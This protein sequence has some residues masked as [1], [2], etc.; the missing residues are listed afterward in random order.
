M[1]NLLTALCLLPT[2]V[3]AQELHTFKNGEVAD[4]EKINQNFDLLR[5][6]NGGTEISVVA[7]CTEDP[8]AFSRLW[9]DKSS[10]KNVTFIV[11]GDCNVSEEVRRHLR[12]L[13]AR[14]IKIKGEYSPDRTCPS[15][16]SWPSNQY[17]QINV[18]H[19]MLV[20]GCLTI[21]G[22]SDFDEPDLYSQTVA[23][24]FG[25]IRLAQVGGR[26][27]GSFQ[28]RRSG[29][30]EANISAEKLGYVSADN[31]SR[32][33]VRCENESEIDWRSIQVFSG[34]TLS[35][36]SCSASGLD[37]IYS[38]E[39]GRASLQFSDL[40]VSYMGVQSS[41]QLVFTNSNLSVLNQLSVSDNSFMSL[42]SEA[43]ISA[44][45][46]IVQRGGQMTLGARSVLQS[47]ELTVI[48]GSGVYWSAQYGASISAVNS[49]F[50]ATSYIGSTSP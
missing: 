13:Q 9:I 34:S 43:S 25:E 20:F 11:S 22:F 30:I 26:N 31:N 29:I 38:E 48:M 32:L 6:M 45:K 14:F 42:Q 7:N 18:S 17:H 27:L 46:T 35:V 21:K 33:F 2:L 40:I 23:E 4:A 37:S 50:D 49:S 12:A 41:S 19:G 16:L 15:S 47:D 44:P 5:D 8:D 3:L 36:S 1:R 10:F 28:A 39:G 24:R